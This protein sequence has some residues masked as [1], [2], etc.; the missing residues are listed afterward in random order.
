MAIILN[1]EEKELA[2]QQASPVN[3]G[4][5]INSGQ[6]A[7]NRPQGSGLFT[8]L[9]K[10]IQANQ[11]SKGV[12]DGINRINSQ[13]D[14]AKKQYDQDSANFTQQNVDYVRPDSQLKHIDQFMKDTDGEL[15]NINESIKEASNPN[16]GGIAPSTVINNLQLRKQDLE[17]KAATQAKDYYN[18]VKSI[19]YNDPS[20]D[21]NASFNKVNSSLQNVNKAKDFI[22]DSDKRSEFLKS[23]YNQSGDYNSGMGRL[24]SFLVNNQGR[25]Q[26]QAR[27]QALDSLS[28]N[29]KGVANHK[30][31]L[32]DKIATNKKAYDQ[33]K[34]SYFRKLNKYM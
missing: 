8:N 6:A 17:Q 14:Q 13:A 9:N 24:D 33:T 5:S 7:S 1:E 25:D 20:E 10:Y 12:K 2:K 32:D 4:Q 28:H 26:F 30:K 11:G 21:I 31:V 22:N 19:N 34:K 29:Y 16:W 3:S 27:K 18:D 23:Q 15:I